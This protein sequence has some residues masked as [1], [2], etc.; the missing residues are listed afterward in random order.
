[1]GFANVYTLLY[2]DFT[3][4]LNLWNWVCIIGLKCAITHPVW[5]TMAVSEPHERGN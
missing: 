4:H 1:M 2:A 5:V 3:Q